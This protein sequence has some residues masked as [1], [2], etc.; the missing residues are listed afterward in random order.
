MILGRYLGPTTDV[1]SALTAKILKLNGQYVCRS[2]LCHLTDEELQ[3]PMHKTLR[4]DF[5]T[6]VIDVLGQSAQA[7][8]F[9]AKDTT[10]DHDHIDPLDLRNVLYDIYNYKMQ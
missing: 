8:D 7:N 6:L 5:L 2:M 4:N 9:P 10:P 1:R 3:C